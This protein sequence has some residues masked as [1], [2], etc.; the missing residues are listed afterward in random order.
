MNSDESKV[1][2]YKSLLEYSKVFLTEIPS[3]Q[4][5]SSS[6]NESI[7]QDEKKISSTRSSFNDIDKD[8]LLK[9]KDCQQRLS[10]CSRR[11]LSL[12]AF[13]EKV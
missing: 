13:Q 11:K 4:S 3:K 2:L 7:Y 6:V 5:R 9:R 1:F 10:L 12:L 8:L